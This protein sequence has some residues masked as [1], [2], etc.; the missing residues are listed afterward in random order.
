MTIS[1]PNLKKTNPKT[2]VPRSKTPK[3]LLSNTPAIYKAKKTP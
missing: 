3:Q 1:Q 2:N